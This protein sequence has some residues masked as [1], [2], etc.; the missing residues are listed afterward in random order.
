M[1]PKKFIT[2]HFD[3]FKFQM[4]KFFRKIVFFAENAPVCPVFCAEYADTLKLR[5]GIF[6]DPKITIFDF[7]GYISQDLVA[8][9]KNAQKTQKKCVLSHSSA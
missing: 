1:A 4:S 3:I 9:T 7:S 2:F 8:K 6:F 5:F